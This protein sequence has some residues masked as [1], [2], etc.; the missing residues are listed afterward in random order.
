[1]KTRNTKQQ[2]FTL[3]E[4]MIVVAIIGVLAAIAVPQYQNYVAK[5]EASSA[6]ATITGIRTNVETHVLGEGA[7]PK[8]EELSAVGITNGGETAL[9]KISLKESDKGAGKIIFTFN[10][11]GVSP[12][13]TNQ[14]LTLERTDE[15]YWKCE[16]TIDTDLQPKACKTKKEA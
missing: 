6:L 1:M 4:L 10:P 16:T 7:F 14:T 9:G 13:I 3:I 2:G 8:E 12:K 11:T 5:S 15:G